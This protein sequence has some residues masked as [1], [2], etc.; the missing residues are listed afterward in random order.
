MLLALTLSCV[1]AIQINAQ[2][3]GAMVYITDYPPNPEQ[4]PAS[5]KTAGKA[6]FAC[7]LNYFAWENY[8]YWVGADGYETEA[9]QISNEVKVG[10]VLG[11]VFCLWPLAIWSYGPQDGPLWIELEKSRAE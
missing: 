1:A 6:P 5:Y 8:Y 3:A 10:P 7:E 9:G 2:P 4:K 11:A